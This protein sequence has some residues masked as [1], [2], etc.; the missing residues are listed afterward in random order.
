MT[1]RSPSQRLTA[2]QLAGV[3]QRI[4]QAPEPERTLSAGEALA[5]LVPVLRKMLASGHTHDSICAVL[6]AEDLHVSM[7]ALRAALRT[8][9][10][11]TKATVPPTDVQARRRVGL[12]STGIAHDEQ[13][14]TVVRTRVQ[15]ER[16]K[17]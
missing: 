4:A 15:A 13:Q 3:A 16:T 7:R 6:A 12:S 5:K 10:V 8:P 2:V 1:K 17:E 9:K 11:K 14:A